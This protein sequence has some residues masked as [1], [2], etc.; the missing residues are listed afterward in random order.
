MSDQTHQASE[1]HIRAQHVKS[2]RNKRDDTKDTDMH[3]AAEPLDHNYLG[4]HGGPRSRGV[5]SRGD[6][7]GKHMQEA[8][9]S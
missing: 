4:P 7:G 2:A 3:D 5:R 1:V 9:S 6:Q 8:G